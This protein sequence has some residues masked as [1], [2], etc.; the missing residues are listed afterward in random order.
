MYPAFDA[1]DRYEMIETQIPANS[2]AT[3]FN[4]NDQPQ[5]RTDQTQDVIIQGL[6]TYTITDIPLSPNAVAVATAL[7]M[8]ST[9]LVLYVNG[10]ES[11]FRIPLVKLHTINNFTDAFNNGE[12]DTPRFENLLVDWTKSYFLTPAAYGGGVFTTFSFLIGVVYKKLP[13]NTI[14]KIRQ[15]QYVSYMNIKLLQLNTQ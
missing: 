14:G 8:K 7:E 12:A 13:P 15:N 9:Y 11:I 6:E 5:L 10:E 4:F 2:T 1:T 3:R